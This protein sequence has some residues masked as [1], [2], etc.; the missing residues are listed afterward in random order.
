[1]TQADLALY[2]A[3]TPNGQKVSIFLKEAGLTYEQFDLDL[4]KGD[5]HQPEFLKINPNGKIPAIVDRQARL[6]VFESGAIL[7]YLSSQT[8]CL[9]PETQA[10][11]VAVQQ[12]LHFQIGG[13]GPMLG[14]LWWFLHA[15]TTGNAE[16]IQRYRKQSLRLYQVVD[17]R[18]SESAFIASEN[19][20]I[21]DIAAFTWLR[22]WEELDL[23]I[24][25]YSHVQRWLDVIAA[26]PAVQAGLLAN[27]PAS[28]AAPD[29]SVSTEG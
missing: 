20:S 4:E 8:G 22:T 11:S 21:A 28:R 15:S 23:D 13:I 27:K 25:S 17:T 18:L 19:Y 29:R 9:Q 3:D 12:W 24:R 10:E 26:R 14:Q 6:A 2:T 5:Q 16:A 7:S 1:M